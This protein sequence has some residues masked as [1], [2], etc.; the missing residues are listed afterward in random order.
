MT[1]KISIILN[2]KHKRHCKNIKKIFSELAANNKVE[3]II[4]S[5]PYQAIELT[6]NAIDK[7]NT[8]IV[9]SAG[10]DGTI[11][12]VVNGILKANKKCLYGII[13]CGSS[14]DFIKTFGKHN[15][16]K[17]IERNSVKKI[18]AAKIFFQTNKKIRYFLNI[19]ELGLGAMTVKRTKKI[20]ISS[21]ITYTINSILTMINFKYQRVKIFI[22]NK[23]YYTGEITAL[24]LA[25][26]IYFG[27]G[28]AIAPKALI[29]DGLMDIVLVKKI[30][31]VKFI[32]ALPQIRRKQILTYPEIEYI[33]AKKVE[34]NSIENYP[35]EADGEDIGYSPLKAKILPQALNM[36]YYPEL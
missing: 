25:N 34:I 10:G 17:A 6:K 13:P 24:I 15:I 33:K 31:L 9:I 26:G 29:D 3:M 11:N 2:G 12:E 5:K 28:L 21:K 1:K 36:L 7:N 23:E 18:D 16:I 35:I 14:N 8:D 22:D 20:F 32:K 4:T 30:P 19:A 27:N